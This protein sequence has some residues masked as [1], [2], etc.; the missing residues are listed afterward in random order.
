MLLISRPTSNFDSLIYGRQEMQ[1]KPHKANIF[2][3]P[4]FQKNRETQHLVTEQH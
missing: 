3:V 1:Q 4:A 2:E